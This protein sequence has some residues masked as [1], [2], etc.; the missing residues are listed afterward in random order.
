MAF[1][2]PASIDVI[3]PEQIST[4]AFT[5]LAQDILNDLVH[6]DAS[7]FK[8]AKDLMLDYLSDATDLDESQKAGIFSDFLKDSYTQINQQAIGAAID[9]RKANAQLTYERYKVEGDYNL[10]QANYQKLL[11]DAS[12]TAKQEAKID[13]DILLAD[14]Q[15]KTQAAARMEGL[16]KLIKQ[17]GFGSANLDTG[18]LGASTN[19]GALD[20]QII[21]YDK[22]NY[23]DTL[24]AINEM[25]AL[26][27]NANTTPGPWMVD[28]QKMLI[29][30]ITLVE[31]EGMINIAGGATSLTDTTTT[32]VAYQTG[33]GL[34]A[35]V[36]TGV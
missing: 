13:K 22:V 25:T 32:T 1:D 12:L 30:L 2:N 34:N 35:Y 9:I 18:V 7:P 36:G 29:E 19:D 11:A 23:K 27:I 5:E 16:A 15:I 24:K 33:T 21:G 14:E 3:T 20:K 6:G 28:V 26:L 17:Y 31:G 10:A 8:D 4:T